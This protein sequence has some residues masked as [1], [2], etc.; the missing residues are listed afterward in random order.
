MDLVDNKG[1]SGYYYIYPNY[2]KGIF[3]HQAEHSG[4]EKA[5]KIW[6]P[7]LD[8]MATYPKML[9]A[10][11]SYVEY[12]T[13]K[14]YFDDRFGAIDKP[15]PMAMEAQ[16]ASGHGHS[17]RRKRGS[18]EAR[19]GPGDGT[20]APVP[21]QIVNLDSRLLGPEHF[22]HPNLTQVMKASSPFVIPVPAIQNIQ[23]HLVSG[24]KAH[25]PD[26]DSKFYQK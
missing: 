24:K 13:F 21:Q 9:K 19:H 4:K 15:M 1:V 22:N 18:I 17:D 6:P 14:A 5:E 10:D 25:N 26:D 20:A 11:R 8:K 3:L 16:P 2:I 12:P 23:G 7:I